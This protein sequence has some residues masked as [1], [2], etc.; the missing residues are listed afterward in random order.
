M[1]AFGGA[2]E[3][4]V[5]CGVDGDGFVAIGDD[6]CDGFGGAGVCG[7]EF[8]ETSFDESGSGACAEGFEV[9]V[10]KSDDVGRKRNGEVNA[11]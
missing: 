9:F 2:F 8:Q 7:K 5:E 6:G 10:D 4:G 3:D 1:E 11:F